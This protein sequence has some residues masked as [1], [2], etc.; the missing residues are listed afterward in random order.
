MSAKEQW[1]VRE[2]L[3]NN[4]DLTGE[5]VVIFSNRRSALDR[6]AHLLDFRLQCG[7][8]NARHYVYVHGDMSIPERHAARDYFAATPSYR[9]S[10]PLFYYT[11][12][13][14]GR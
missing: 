13:M 7:V 4:T 5:K 11:C 1:V 6:L 2:L 8:P 10:S 3:C 9:S 14:K 12:S